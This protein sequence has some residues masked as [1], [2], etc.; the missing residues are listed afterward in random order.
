MPLA[1]M[2]TLGVT[3]SARRYFVTLT[4]A[5][6]GAVGVLTPVTLAGAATPLP[7][8]V[9]VPSAPVYGGAFT[10]SVTAVTG[11]AT[12]VTSLSSSTCT[13]NALSGVVS[14]VAAGSC[15]LQSAEA[16]SGTDTALVG[17]PQFFTIA[18]ATLIVTA[19]SASMAAGATPVAITPLITGFVGS[20]TATSLSVAPVCQT[21]ALSTSASGSYPSY[22]SGAQA[23]NYT[24]AYVV[25]T[26]SVGLASASTPTITNLPTADTFGNTY[27]PTIATNAD[28]VA[29][30]VS[31]TPLV[32]S[33]QGTNTVTY[34]RTGTCTLQAQVAAGNQFA[35]SEG[36]DQSYPVENPAAVIPMTYSV[37]NWWVGGYQSS[38]T[39]NNTTPINFGT[40]S[41]PWSFSFV[42]PT[43][44]SIDSFWGADEVSTPTD[45]GTLV[46]VTAPGYQPVLK[47]GTSYSIG[48]TTKGNG[49]VQN[50]MMGGSACSMPPLNVPGIPNPPVGYAVLNL[51]PSGYQGQYLLS[52]NTTANIGSPA[53]PWTLSF[54]LPTG[55]SIIRLWGGDLSTAAVANGTQVTVTGPNANPVLV[56]GATVTVGFTTSGTDA[57]TNCLLN[58]V[59]CPASPSPV[60]NVKATL[61]GGVAT[62]TWNAPAST[63]SS[64]IT[65][66]VVTAS[67]SMK[68][69]TLAGL[70]VTKNSC[71]FRGLSAGASYSFQVAAINGENLSSGP[72]LPSNSVTPIGA[73]TV[74]VG[75]GVNLDHG[76][77][78]I[79]WGAPALMG[80]STLTGFTVVA[81]PAATAPQ[82]CV[83]TMKTSCTFVGLVYGTPYTF[84]VV[85]SN[86]A[87][88]TSAPSAPTNAVMPITNPAAPTNVTAVPGDGTVVVTWNQPSFTGGSPLT[89][90]TVTSDLGLNCGAPVVDGSTASCTYNGLAN[91]LPTLFVVRAMNRVGL[92][93]EYSSPSPS[94][95]PF[96]APTAPSAP[97]GLHAVAGNGQ[98]SVSWL[99][100][101]SNGG[102]AI[103][104]YTVALSPS[105]MVPSSCVMSTAL[106]CVITGLDNYV[107][108]SVRVTATNALGTSVASSSVTAAPIAGSVRVRFAKS[109]ISANGYQ[110]HYRVRNPTS[111]PIGSQNVPWS[112]SFDLPKGTSLASFWGANHSTRVLRG[113]TT[114]TVTPL[115]QNSTLL[116]GAHADVYFTTYGAGSPANCRSIGST[117][118]R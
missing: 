58:N 76:T 59:V 82:S 87:G 96:R 19:S 63:G 108:Y 64:A 111:Q 49:S 42:L 69:C 36:P 92:M 6:L 39:L 103:T 33:V 20:D 83:M 106:Q 38:I 62:V 5:M 95:T 57:P 104:G 15:I 72:S 48:F 24:F 99:T 117:C 30:V 105:G 18:P 11:G 94:V 22:C 37:T 52:N 74:P 40:S 101:R 65:S 14:F 21:T 113:V 100:P 60:T 91:G 46:T 88:F 61:T 26:V 16:A 102:K 67:G 112:F 8:I 89:G 9:N 116:A 32:C 79:T 13:V 4:L 41:S 27:T 12:S 29:G 10:P 3:S 66:Y 107:N 71:V 55:T 54:V 93:S 97:Q 109:A 75:V 35:A 114:V 80:G 23:T 1:S 31:L 85:A 17:E 28:G 68:T 34:L 110:G 70:D 77:A 86:A 73:P 81:S 47:P 25:G 98:I 90:Y 78:T 118:Q 2:P 7:T 43:D 84:S 115:L 56:P 53:H 44:T 45:G 51:S 50:C